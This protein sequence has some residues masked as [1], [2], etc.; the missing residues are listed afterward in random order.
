MKKTKQRIARNLGLTT[1]SFGLIS[2]GGGST[3]PSQNS[4]PVSFLKFNCPGSTNVAFPGV[5]GIRQV[6]GSESEV[7]IT[8][9]YVQYGSNHG[10]VYRGPLTGGGSCYAYNYPS[11]VGITVTSTSLYGPDNNGFGQVVAVGSYTTLESGLIAQQ[12]FVYQGAADG[13]TRTGYTTLYP[14]TLTA[15][16]IINTIA[17]STMGGMVVGNYDTDVVTGQGFIYNMTSGSYYRLV[18]PGGSASLTVY[19]IWYNGGTSYTLTGGY[20]VALQGGTNI[21]FITDWDSNTQQLRNFTSLNYNS[22]AVESVGTHFEGI[23]SAGNGGYN[24]A[25]DWQYSGQA[26]TPAFAHV[27]RAADG[28]FAPAVWTGFNYFPGAYWTSANTVYRN[29]VLGLY[30]MGSPLLDFGYVATITNY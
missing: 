15:D 27:A 21:G 8:G 7:Y 24:L 3:G 17:H 4:N 28:G 1:L 5:S 23:T 19:G 20:S 2:C 26:T 11:S 29:N 18:K 10:F 12:G 13:S 25:A 22:Y 30:Q 16:P 9:V 14:G 6:A